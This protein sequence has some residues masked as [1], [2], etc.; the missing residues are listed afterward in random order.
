MGRCCGSDLLCCQLL[1]LRNRVYQLLIL[2]DMRSTD[3]VQCA[4]FLSF[5]NK[6]RRK[7][8]FQKQLFYVLKVLSVLCLLFF[9]CSHIFYYDLDCLIE[10]RSLD[11]SLACDLQRYNSVLHHDLQPILL[12]CVCPVCMKRIKQ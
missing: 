4:T 3:C 7:R 9:L 1:T 12:A 11:Y 2:W 8:T 5:K 6:R 10:I